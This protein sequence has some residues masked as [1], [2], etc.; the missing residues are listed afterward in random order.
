MC[1]NTI[2]PSNHLLCLKKKIDF[3]WFWLSSDCFWENYGYGMTRNFVN[4][5][6]E[7][8]PW[9]LFQSLLKQWFNVE[10][11]WTPFIHIFFWNFWNF[12]RTG[13]KRGVKR[14]FD[15]LHIIPSYIFMQKFNKKMYQSF[16]M[17]PLCLVDYFGYLYQKCRFTQFFGI[18]FFFV[19]YSA[20]LQRHI[21]HHTRRIAMEEREQNIL[22]LEG[23]LL[24]MLQPL[25]VINYASSVSR[26]GCPHFT[27]FLF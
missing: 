4:L 6:K 12:F 11:S 1:A 19:A 17:C 8:H 3:Y 13:R 7:R 22:L 14:F 10:Q 16:F 23:F 2:H 25:W 18:Y 5:S 27:Y 21:T 20:P 24:L 26:C 9:P 15:H